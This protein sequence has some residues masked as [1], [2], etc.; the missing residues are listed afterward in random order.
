MGTVGQTFLG[1]TTN[2]A[3]CH[4]HK[5]DPIR[6]SEYYAFCSA[7][8][9]VHHGE[10][11]ITDPEVIRA[12]KQ[13]AG[14]NQRENCSARSSRL[15]SW[16]SRSSRQSQR[17]RLN[18]KRRTIRQQRFVS[19][20]LAHW[21]FAEGLEDQIGNLHADLRGGAKLEDGAVVLDGKE[22][23][24]ATVPIGVDIV[25]KTLAVRVT[26]SDLDQRG[27]GVMTLLSTKVGQFDSVVFGEREP[28]RWMA[29]SENFVR[30]KNVGG[31]EETEATSSTGSHCDHL[32][33]RRTIKFIAMASFTA[34]PTKPKRHRFIERKNSV[35]AFGIRHFP[36][37]GNRM[38]AGRIH[39]ASLYDRAL[40]DDEVRLLAGGASF[41]TDDV[42]VRYMTPEQLQTVDVVANRDQEPSRD[43]HIRD[44]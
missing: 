25:E 42:M 13:T 1:L 26:L 8:D 41:I 43:R 31:P 10:R 14:G 22:A 20:P 16:R 40:S 33:R 39:Q 17:N 24:V 35:V 3:R 38:L 19:Q 27:G 21:N 37:G 29:G 4:D 9:G 34:W 5:F 18:E 28:K 32:F 30:S 12:A 6:Q 11:D 7:L 2:C 44:A 15:P 36:A 23:H